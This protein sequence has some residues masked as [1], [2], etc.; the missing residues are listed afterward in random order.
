MYDGDGVNAEVF[1]FVTEEHRRLAQ[2][3]SP[4]Y[5]A[6]VGFVPTGWVH[7][8]S[9]S[10]PPA[11]RRKVDGGPFDGGRRRRSQ[12][13]KAAEA[14]AKSIRKL[15]PQRA[16][17]RDAEDTPQEEIPR[18]EG[19]EAGSGG[20]GEGRERREGRGCLRTWCTSCRTASTPRSASCS[21]VSSSSGR[22]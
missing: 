7:S 12:K 14:E 19:E 22:G 4:T 1:S 15:L 11:I 3:T 10:F 16:T 9:V 8:K 6:V 2:L 21:R 20:G 5:T 18:G 17:S 13:A